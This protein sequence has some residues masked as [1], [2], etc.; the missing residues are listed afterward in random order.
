M[1]DTIDSW[2]EIT[3]FRSGEDD[4]YIVEYILAD[5][6]GFCHRASPFL[7]SVGTVFEH[8]FGTYRVDE[9]IRNIK[10]IVLYCNRIDRTHKS[11]DL[12]FKIQNEQN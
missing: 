6:G 7:M 10:H 9:I 4:E 5:D 1:G 8:E 11:F 3:D 12:L 2:D